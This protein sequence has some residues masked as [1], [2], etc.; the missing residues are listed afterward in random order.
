MK[1]ISIRIDNELFDEIE[2]KRG[3]LPKSEFYRSVI[4]EYILN[5]KNDH[6]HSDEYTQKLTK[7]NEFLK[8]K[9]DDLLKLLNQEQSLHLQT[10]RQLPPAGESFWGRL[11][12]WGKE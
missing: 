12:H 5:T 2:E 6:L 9:V 10:Q 8:N 7:D 3:D 11:K 1:T 4:S